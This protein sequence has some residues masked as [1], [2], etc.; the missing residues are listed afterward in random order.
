MMMMMMPN[1]KFPRLPNLSSRSE[2]SMLSAF[3]KSELSR[4]NRSQTWLKNLQRRSY[5][6]SCPRITRSQYQ[7]IT[8]HYRAARYYTERFSDFPIK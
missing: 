2:L 8:E 4:R 5:S 1:E 6:C 7:F 3:Q